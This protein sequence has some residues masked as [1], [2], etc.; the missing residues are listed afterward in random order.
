MDT[1]SNILQR[2]PYLTTGSIL[3]DQGN[4]FT[5]VFKTH[6]LAPVE[7]APNRC[8]FLISWKSKMNPVVKYGAYLDILLGVSMHGRSISLKENAQ[9]GPS[10]T[11]H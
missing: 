7:P 10:S 2:T 1:L 4:V 8:I 11:P 6:L 9:M 3:D 5:R